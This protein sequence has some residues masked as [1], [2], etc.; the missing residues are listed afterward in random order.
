MDASTKYKKAEMEERIMPIKSLQA[1]WRRETLQTLSY[2][3]MFMTTMKIKN[4]FCN[5]NVKC[6]KSWDGGGNNAYKMFTSWV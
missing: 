3:E 1:G 2:A 4:N 6:E 5:T